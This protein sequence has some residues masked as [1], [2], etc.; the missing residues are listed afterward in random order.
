MNK[1]PSH[2]LVAV[3][4]PNVSG[5]ETLE[6]LMVRDKLVE[7]ESSLTAEQKTQLKGAD[8][9][10]MEQAAEFHIELIQP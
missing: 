4:H 9:R 2:Y 1:Y 5:F 8:Q 3:E 7:Q 6:M 10:L